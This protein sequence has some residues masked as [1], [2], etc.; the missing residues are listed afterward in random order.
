MT[1]LITAGLV[2]VLIAGLVLAGRK[3]ELRDRQLLRRAVVII[4]TANTLAAG[5]FVWNMSGK[6]L[7]S[8]SRD[9]HGEG[10]V[11]K[12]LRL[13]IEGIARSRAVDVEISGQAYSKEEEEKYV[14]ACRADLEK[15]VI[16]SG[17][18]ADHVTKDLTLPERLPGNPTR[19]R[20]HQDDYS[21]LDA[22]GKID[23]LSVAAEGSSVT[24]T[25]ELSCGSTEDEVE[26]PVTVYP[27]KLGSLGGYLD[28]IGR[29]IKKADEQSLT[30]EKVPLPAQAGGRQLVWREEPGQE[31]YL[32]IV[33]G[34][35]TAAFLIAQHREKERQRQKDRERKLAEDHPK[36]LNLFSMLLRAGMTPGHVWRLI[37]E[38]YEKQKK[39]TGV[40]PAFEV[41]AVGLRKM[42]T[43]V[44]QEEVYLDFG[45]SCGDVRYERF[46]H[47]LARNMR[48]G[49]SG[50]AD[51]LAGEAREAFQEQKR[52]AR[53]R[54][55]EAQTKLL[56]PMMILLLIVLVVVMVPAFLS[57][58]IQ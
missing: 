20:W 28:E 43:G 14:R 41:M 19:I 47:L 26:I 49:S 40:R 38:D 37:V 34:I 42:A 18:R 44:A 23:T 35:V 53:R 13:K 36:I 24:L 6:T 54:G 21:V 3:R 4:L 5:L 12:R 9:S 56:L 39:L 51:Q 27:R 1:G 16:G 33:L 25:A 8:V 29:L 55:E 46:G 57:M 45:R 2:Y 10:T 31:G 30:E 58:Q 7:S 32:L 17:Q 22:T 52:A 50:L 15:V 11:T 48:R